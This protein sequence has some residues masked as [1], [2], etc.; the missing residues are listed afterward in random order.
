MEITALCN[1]KDVFSESRFLDLMLALE[2]HLE[3]I[4]NQ[5]R[6]DVAQIFLC[7]LKNQDLHF[8]VGCGFQD[9]YQYGVRYQYGE[10]LVGRVAL[11]RRPLLIA[12]LTDPRNATSI[13]TFIECGGFITYYGA[14]LLYNDCLL[15][16]LE[17][18]CCQLI[19]FDRQWF[20][21]IAN[22]ADRISTA[23]DA[24]EYYQRIIDFSFGV[25]C[26]SVSETEL[27]TF[28]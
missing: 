3:H 7:D 11:K 26:Y 12:D 18:F 19:E 8:A 23:I 28:T 20:E 17:V 16:V 6:V 21:M 10:G 27:L 9:I 4:V 1:A 13:N 15:G 22:S 14:P 25:D 24:A 5:T 2:G